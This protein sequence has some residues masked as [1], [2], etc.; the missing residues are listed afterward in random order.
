[1]LRSKGNQRSSFTYNTQRQAIEKAREIA[2]KEHLELSIHAT[3]H[4]RLK[5][6]ISLLFQGGRLKTA[7]LFSLL[8]NY[9]MT[10]SSADKLLSLQE[11]LR[12]PVVPSI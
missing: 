8:L 9:I 3:T 7:S 11:I 10:C 4:S 12:F 2:R 1:M 6:S 5:A